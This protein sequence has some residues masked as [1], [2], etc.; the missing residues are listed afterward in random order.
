M[1]GSGDLDF[2]RVVYRWVVDR[3][4][5]VFDPSSASIMPACGISCGK[6]LP[7]TGSST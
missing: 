6:R 1:G 2:R 4:I 5:K 3:G 7:M